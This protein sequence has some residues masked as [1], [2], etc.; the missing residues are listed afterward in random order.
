MILFLIWRWYQSL[1]CLLIWRLVFE[2]Q[3]IHRIHRSFLNVCTSRLEI[4]EL[5]PIIWIAQE[6]LL[7]FYSLLLLLT[8]LVCRVGHHFELLEISLQIFSNK[9]LYLL[10]C[11][12][13]LIR[14]DSGAP[15][16]LLIQSKHLTS[17]GFKTCIFLAILLF[18]DSSHL[19]WILKGYKV[20]ACFSRAAYADKSSICLEVVD[21]VNKV[22]MLFG[23]GL[24]E[25]ICVREI[26]ILSKCHVRLGLE[27]I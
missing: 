16:F 18:I 8:K 24:S 21:V 26:S 23:E 19:L 7:I 12:E 15:S 17:N 25:E 13:L 6:R 14:L 10:S 9:Q 2:W 27:L 20:I 11:D 4:N 5:L 1:I 3:R 22:L